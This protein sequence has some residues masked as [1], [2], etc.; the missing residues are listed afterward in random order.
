MT[1]II[2]DRQKKNQPKSKDKELKE[3]L[4]TSLISDK[5]DEDKITSCYTKSESPLNLSKIL[6]IL[7]GIPERTDK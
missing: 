7:D 3:N 5:I 6:N 1:D 4:L 2:E